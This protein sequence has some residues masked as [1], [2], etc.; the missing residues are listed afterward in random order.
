[1]KN[2]RKDE[3]RRVKNTSNVNFSGRSKRRPYWIM[4]IVIIK[5]FQFTGHILPATLYPHLFRWDEG[6][7]QEEAVVVGA[8]RS[9]TYQPNDFL[10]TLHPSLVGKG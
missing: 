7:L 9:R 2:K 6:E 10:C 8:A 1:M 4:S 5:K 3:A